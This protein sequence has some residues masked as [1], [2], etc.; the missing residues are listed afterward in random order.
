MGKLEEF[1]NKLNALISEIAT[2]K[3][4]ITYYD[5]YNITDAVY[6]KNEFDAKVNALVNNSSLVVNTAAPFASNEVMYYPGDIVLKN[7]AGDLIHINA[8]TSG[9]YY[10]KRI[11]SAKDGTGSYTIYY[12]YVKDTPEIE[13]SKVAVDSP[14]DAEPAQTISF[15]GLAAAKPKDSAVYGLYEQFGSTTTHTINAVKTSDS[16][17]IKPLIKFYLVSDNDLE[18]ISLQYKLTF[19]ND[20]YTITISQ[21]IANLYIEVK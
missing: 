15:S 5:V 10:P 17:L 1:Q 2:V 20:I 3:K 16:R 9:T 12:G 8:Q 13:S 19:A 14:A 21:P 18:E 6:D 11:E 4:N 7:A